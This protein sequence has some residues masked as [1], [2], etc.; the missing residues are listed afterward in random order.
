M[1]IKC[2]MISLIFFYEKIKD[3]KIHSNLNFDYYIENYY[4]NL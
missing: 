4:Y 1:E 3:L 2:L